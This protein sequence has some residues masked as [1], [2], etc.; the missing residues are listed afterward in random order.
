MQEIELRQYI[1]TAE[2]YYKIV[3]LLLNTSEF[4]ISQIARVLQLKH[5]TAAT[6][7]TR[8]R[9]LGIIKVNKVKAV[10]GIAKICELVD[11][12]TIRKIIKT[13]EKQRVLEGKVDN[14]EN[15]DLNNNNF[16]FQQ[17]FACRK[18]VFNAELCPNCKKSDCHYAGRV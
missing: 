2:I 7:I 15:K 14:I 4:N 17:D 12:E 11:P 5:S 10:H 8:L 18:H 16:A 1:L 9:K 3:K 6:H 13:E